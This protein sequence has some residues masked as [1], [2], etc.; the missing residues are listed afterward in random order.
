MKKILRLLLLSFIIVSCSKK[1]TPEPPVAPP[2]YGMPSEQI[3]KDI[4][5]ENFDGTWMGLYDEVGSTKYGYSVYNDTNYTYYFINGEAKGTGP[6][7][8]FSGDASYSRND[9]IVTINGISTLIIN[10]I[11]E[12]NDDLYMEMSFVNKNYY[13]GRASTSKGNGTALLIKLKF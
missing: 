5:V 4:T 6:Y 11:F 1:E 7:T 8:V 12:Y 10:R 9:K 2:S 13:T 3:N